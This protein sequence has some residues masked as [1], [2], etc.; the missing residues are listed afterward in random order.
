MILGLFGNVVLVTL[1]KCYGNTCG[2]KNVIEIYVVLCCLN[3]ENCCLN[4]TTKQPPRFF[5]LKDKCYVKVKRCFLKIVRVWLNF[6][7]IVIWIINYQKWQ[8]VRKIEF[9]S[10]WWNLVCSVQVKVIAW[11]KW[12]ASKDTWPERFVVTS[13]VHFISHSLPISHQQRWLPISQN[14][15]KLLCDENVEEKCTGWKMRKKT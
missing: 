13:K 15:L 3:N 9:L 7:K 5:Y 14:H 6:I 4:N 11:E 8:Y 10:I 12:Q 1:F 2:W